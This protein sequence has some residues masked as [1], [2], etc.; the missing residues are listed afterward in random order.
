MGGVGVDGTRC[1]VSTKSKRVSVHVGITLPIKVRT[2]FPVSVQNP[3]SNTQ[4]K[5]CSLRYRQRPD[6]IEGRSRSSEEGRMVVIS[7]R[8][9]TFYIF[10]AF[11]PPSESRVPRVLLQ[12]HSLDKKI[13]G[14]RG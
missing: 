10:G 14:R 9:T 1:V 8:P 13:Y 11:P 7:T 6:G 12:P 4:K 3:R 5:V 2:W